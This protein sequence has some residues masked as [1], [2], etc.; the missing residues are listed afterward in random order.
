MSYR[1]LLLLCLLLPLGASAAS[2]QA[3]LDRN[4]VRL[5]E[6]VTLNVR[7]NGSMNANTPDLSVLDNDFEVLGS[8]TNSSL[9]VVNGRQNA[10]LIIGI[11]LRP[12]HVGD[13]QIPSLTVAGS[14]TAPLTLHVGPPD[15]STSTSA[16]KDI[17]IETSAAPDHVYT[18]QQ[19]LY[20]V[21]LFLA[22]NLNGGTLPDP[23]PDGVDVRRLGN[24]TDYEVER[25]G[26]RY[27]V[28]ERR[29]AMIPQRAGAL[30]IPSIEFQ[31]EA[32]EPGNPNDPGSFFGQ[33]G[34]FGNT[35]PVTADSSPVSVDVQAAP[36]DW[37]ATSW[38]PARD[39]TLKVEG[40]PGDDKAQVGQPINLRM[41]IDAK[42]LPAES[43]PEPSLPAIDGATVYPDQ[44]TTAT[45]D[46]GQWLSGHRGRGFAIFPQHAGTL[47]I[48]AISLTWFDVQ[49]GQK[50]TAAIPAHT[51][52]VAAAA[53]SGPTASSSTGTAAAPVPAQ[54]QSA[55]QGVPAVSTTPWRWI[56]LGSIGLWLI[57]MLAWWWSRRQ[58]QTKP[59]VSGP[60]IQE[61]SRASRQAFMEAARG[62]DRATQA[63]RLLAWARSERPGLHNLGQLSAALASE[64]QR[65]AIERLQQLQYA[66]AGVD[67][68]SDLAAVF[69]QGFDWKSEGGP[70]QDSPLPPLYPFK[71]D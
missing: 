48:P 16:R 41:S 53:N 12:K 11:A 52:T 23:H 36:A 47:T 43:L 65:A 14:Q 15:T 55:N 58:R 45:H 64:P 2:V 50:K 40:L 51:L 9:T 71:L 57:S 28:I 4:D 66:R 10:E 70:Q 49:S 33:G 21:R 69:A 62:N 27:Q 1:W 29:Y 25:N 31:G 5:G 30:T 24:D 17:F 63:R 19:L 22:V 56:A 37:G 68:G 26:R 20:T 3:S 34:L 7:I 8:S 46:D 35:S 44:S 18:G 42:G 38:L 67:D 59:P 6:T 39:L 60:S 54:A 32:V 61:S 13:L